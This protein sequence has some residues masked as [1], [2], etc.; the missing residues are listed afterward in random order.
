MPTCS[1]AP[2]LTQ[3]QQPPSAP[4][5]TLVWRGEV[6][7]SITA[8]VALALTQALPGVCDGLI[9]KTEH[10]TQHLCAQEPLLTVDLTQALAWVAQALQT[11]GRCGPWR[12]ERVP[13]TN[14][15]GC[16]VALVE[17]GV[18]RV[19][20]LR[21][22][23]VHLVG[24]VPGGAVW[25]QQRSLTKPNDPGLWD[26]LM[27]GTVAGDETVADTLARET[28]E[29]A[30]LHLADLTDVL[31]R[32]HFT[33]T[34]PVPDGGGEGHLVE[35]TH[36]YTATVPQGLVPVNQDGEV[37]HFECWAEPQVRLAVAQGRFTPE[38]GWVLTQVLNADSGVGA[39][40]QLQH[41]A[42]GFCGW[43]ATR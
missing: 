2:N 40:T 24:R 27:G 18:V 37:D 5:L 17:R 10:Q 6:V 13:V 7:G 19:L 3:V 34:R 42:G 16:T 9:L 30:G 22:Q 32:G 21:T 15:S 38:A 35:D 1:P 4:R 14:A 12:H 31:H 29:E 11:V 36:W 33:A 25:V 26:T 28:W 8:N 39:F 20:G 23:A 43:N 41:P